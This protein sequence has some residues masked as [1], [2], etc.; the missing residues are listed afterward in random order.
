MED[1][2]NDT[3]FNDLAQIEKTLSDDA[4]G[5]RARA[6]IGYFEQITL[7]SQAMLHKPL[8]ESERRLVGQL[9]EG[10]QASQRI[11]KHVWETLHS[12]SLHT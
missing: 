12:G 8:P 5:E 4:S 3:I 9:I 7:S 10:F 2:V 11:V 6:M 1:A